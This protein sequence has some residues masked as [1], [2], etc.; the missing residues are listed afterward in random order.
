MMPWVKAPVVFPECM[1]GYRDPE[2][3]SQGYRDPQHRMVLRIEGLDRN[4]ARLVKTS[5]PSYLTPWNIRPRE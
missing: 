1:P 4:P 2:Q 3:H 5:H